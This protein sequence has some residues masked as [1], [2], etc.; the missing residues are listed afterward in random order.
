MAWFAPA[1]ADRRNRGA[2][3]NKH[4]D[5]LHL[6]KAEVCAGYAFFHS[7]ARRYVIRDHAARVGTAGIVSRRDSDRVHGARRKRESSVV[8]ALIELDEGPPPAG[9]G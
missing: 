3:R 8:C 2:A 5:G 9:T 6:A 4:G 1:M 7:A